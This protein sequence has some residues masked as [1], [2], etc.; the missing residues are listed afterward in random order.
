MPDEHQRRTRD[1]GELHTEIGAEEQRVAQ[2]RATAQQEPI[3]LWTRP[4]TQRFRPGT[5]QARG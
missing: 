4:R 5:F 1:E 3:S 2:G